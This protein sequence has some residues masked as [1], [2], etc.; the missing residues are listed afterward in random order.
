M[1]KCR[2]ELNAHHSTS[3]NDTQQQQQHS[4][5]VNDGESTGLQNDFSLVLEDEESEATS[6]PSG[7][8]LG[9]VADSTVQSTNSLTSGA[10]EQDR[11]RVSVH[12][13][14]L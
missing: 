6:G 14:S 5:G 9:R 10:V 2:D 1:F 12:D 11:R 13:N 4:D 7:E 8:P 3:H